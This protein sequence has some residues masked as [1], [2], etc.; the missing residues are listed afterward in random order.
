MVDENA[1]IRKARTVAEQHLAGVK[2]TAEQH[3]QLIEQHLA[4]ARRPAEGSHTWRYR[5][6]DR[7]AISS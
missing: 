6:V 4:S 7:W 2:A 3:Q 5:R 1:P